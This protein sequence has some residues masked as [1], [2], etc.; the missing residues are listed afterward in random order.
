MLG[1]AASI[2]AVIGGGWLGHQVLVQTIFGL[3]D[4][5]R[6]LQSGSIDNKRGSVYD[7]F[8]CRQIP[9]KGTA[10]RNELFHTFQPSLRLFR[11]NWA[12]SRYFYGQLSLAFR[13]QHS[14]IFGKK[15]GA[16]QQSCP[17]GYAEVV[18]L[19]DSRFPKVQEDHSA[20]K[21]KVPVKTAHNFKLPVGQFVVDK[22][23]SSRN[24]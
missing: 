16:L 12:R 5:N 17:M 4:I 22:D 21:Y 23:F 18:P 8:R 19:W 3:I 10:T 11:S 24:L 13:I 2:F 15:T 1:G 9:L 14:N 6:Y 7:G 20:S